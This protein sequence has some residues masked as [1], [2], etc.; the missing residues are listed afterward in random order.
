M[1]KLN[2]YIPITKVDEENRLVYGVLAAEE[3]DNSG[4]IF[5][6]ESS[7]PNFE[8]WSNAQFEASNG[9]SKGNV[10]AMHTS[11][12]AGKLTDISYDDETKV[13]EGCAKV[14]DDGEWQKVLEGVYTGF[15]MGG[16]YAKRWN[17]NGQTRYT[18][19]PVEMSLVDK[20]CIKSA[21]FAGMA[22]SFILQKSDGTVEEREFKVE[23][24]ATDA[25]LGKGHETQNRHDSGKWSGGHKHETATHGGADPSG[26][27]E[28]EAKPTVKTGVLGLAIDKSD[29][30]DT[31]MFVPT[32][33]QMLPVA[34]ALA[35]AAGNE[36]GWLEY[37][38]AARDQLVTEH[39]A[40]NG[41]TVEKKD[42]PFA[43]HSDD[44]CKKED[45]D[46][47]AE[48]AAAAADADGGD[49]TGAANKADTPEDT[50]T[51]GEGPGGEPEADVAKTDAPELQQGWQAK[52]GTFF[53]K[54]ADA[55]AHNDQLAKGDA[56][57]S[58]GQLL[59]AALAVAK[60][61]T[62]ADSGTE[63]V[64]TEETPVTK[65]V[66]AQLLQLADFI[67]GPDLRKGLYDVSSLTSVLR[68]AAS[69]Y[70]SARNEAAREGD[71]SGVPAQLL[72]ATET[73]GQALIAMATEE[74]GEMLTELR[75]AGESDDNYVYPDCCYLS[76]ST[77]G[78]EKAD[79]DEFFAK[80]IGAAERVGRGIKKALTVEPV[81]N[82]LTKA[83]KAAGFEDVNTFTAGIADLQKRAKELEE[84]APK[85]E[86]LTK[87][88]TELKSKPMPAAPRTNVVEK[89]SDVGGIAVG[90]EV[91]PLEKAEQTLAGLSGDE[92]ARLA[93][94]MA[95]QNGHRLQLSQ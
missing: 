3:L 26:H 91:T 49:D 85:V 75:E 83:V 18:A 20:P 17:D 24:D 80:A 66:D 12:A 41:G 62:P 88:V 16:R 36:A 87:F 10:R 61:D 32:N 73:L 89:S 51:G 11:I 84:I 6:Y 76:A 43:E 8:D 94:K 63:V 86:E 44:D 74:V 50:D 59:D 53:A 1:R 19:V 65:S 64:T 78:L 21:L 58:L 31:T 56:P 35:K 72:E 42:N 37:M 29:K 27:G 39:E 9:L 57:T 28:D 22:K 4:E 77:M 82:E 46:K 38:D 69:A 67:A 15:S 52:D 30:G 40:A 47:C 92:I 45:C 70:A 90:G 79:A 33:D 48:K 54:K 5:D 25:G 7:K 93:I 34:Q 2:L 23:D 13:I 55:V 60:S 14:V 71:S 95:Q 68:G 81:E